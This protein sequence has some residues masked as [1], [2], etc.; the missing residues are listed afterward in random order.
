MGKQRVGIQRV[1]IFL[2]AG[3]QEQRFAVQTGRQIFTAQLHD[4]MAFTLALQ[5]L[6]SFRQR[7]SVNPSCC[8][9]LPWAESVVHRFALCAAGV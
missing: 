2:I 7:A 4:V 9:S 8:R 1:S 3:E 5:R 6:Q